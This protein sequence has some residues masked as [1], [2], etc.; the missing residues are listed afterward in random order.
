MAPENIEAF[1]EEINRDA[2]RLLDATH[3]KEFHAWLK[4]HTGEQEIIAN[5]KVNHR[6]AVWLRRKDDTQI[7]PDSLWTSR[8]VYN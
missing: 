4:A 1:I 5:G 2:M 3:K 6:L 8:K 7:F